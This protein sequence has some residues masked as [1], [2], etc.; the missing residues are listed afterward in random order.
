MAAHRKSDRRRVYRCAGG[1][2]KRATGPLASFDW[3]DLFFSTSDKPAFLP[4]PPICPVQRSE[5]CDDRDGSGTDPA[6]RLRQKQ[7]PSAKNEIRCT[8]PTHY[9]TELPNNGVSSVNPV[10]REPEHSGVREGEQP[11]ITMPI[12]NDRPLLVRMDGLDSTNC[13]RESEDNASEQKSEEDCHRTNE[14]KINHGWL[15]WQTRGT[16]FAMGPLESCRLPG[17]RPEVPSWK[18]YD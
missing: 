17:Q 13:R 1:L 15:S 4:P 3:L 11:T 10:E 6:V 8:Q 2:G 7:L 18:H 12:C 9:E 14:K 5:R 16:S